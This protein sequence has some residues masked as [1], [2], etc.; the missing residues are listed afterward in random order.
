[1]LQRKQTFP[2]IKGLNKPVAT[3]DGSIDSIGISMVNPMFS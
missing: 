3:G 1:M 2:S